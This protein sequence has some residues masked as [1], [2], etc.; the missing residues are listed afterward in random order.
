[1]SSIAPHPSVSASLYYLYD[2]ADGPRSFPLLFPQYILAASPI[3]DD[4]Q[5]YLLQLFERE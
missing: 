1:M 4:P 3:S 5:C 2:L